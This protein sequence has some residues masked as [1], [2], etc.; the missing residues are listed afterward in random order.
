MDREK[1]KQQSRRFFFWNVGAFAVIFLLLGMIILQLLQISAYRQTD[2]SLMQMAQDKDRL[3]ME[4]NRYQFNNPIWSA[5]DANGQ[6]DARPNEFNSQFI[7]WSK[8]GKIL[9]QSLLGGRLNQ[10]SNLPFS[11]DNISK[12]VS[13]KISSTQSNSEMSFHS[14]MVRVKDA[15]SN[16][17]YIQILTNTDQIAASM[18]NFQQILIICM[19]IFWLLSIALS[20]SLSRMSMK[21]ILKSW[22]KQQEFVENASHELRTPLTIIQNNL[23]K[24]FTKPNNTIIE[25]SESIAQALTET[26]RLTGLTS[27]LLTIARSDANEMVLDKKEIQ[28]KEFIAELVKPFH[29]IA[30]M[31]EKQF[32]LKNEADRPVLVDPQK[33]HQV[34]VI[35]LDNALKYTKAGDAITMISKTNNDHWLIEVQN[36]GPSIPDGDKKRI[37][38][39]FYREDASRSKETGGYGLGL[40]IAKQIILEHRGKISVHD[41]APHGVVFQISLPIKKNPKK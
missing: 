6:M 30:E 40:A 18:K 5:P 3:E 23:Q 31:D 35:L 16:V 33:I 38:E 41:L 36:T 26:R 15:G 10:L 17:A 32:L 11:T 25:E 27:D 7:L 37:F 19:L 12:I 21:P 34:L 4:I 2:L 20:Y 14:I 29:E 24:L 22:R 8:D 28:P 39:R 1:T 9:N 13:I